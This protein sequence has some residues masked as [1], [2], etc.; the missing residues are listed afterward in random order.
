MPDGNI[1]ILWSDIRY[2]PDGI[3]DRSVFARILKPDGTAVTGDIRVT[4]DNIDSGFA[5]LELT[6]DGSILLVFSSDLDPEGPGSENDVFVRFFSPDDLPKVKKLKP[7]DDDVKL[8]RFDDSVES[9]RGDDKIRAGDGHD[10]IFGQKGNDLLL[11]QS[12]DDLL[13]GGAGNDTLRG[14]PG[15]DLFFGGIGDDVIYVDDDDSFARK[16]QKPAPFD[17]PPTNAHFYLGGWGYDTLVVEKGSTFRFK[18]L[19]TLSIE[20]FVGADGDDR[21]A[22]RG[23]MDNMFKGGGGDDTLIGM[24][25]DD[26]L[27]GGAGD[28]RLLGGHGM[29]VLVGGGG[30]DRLVGDEDRDLLRGGGDQDT[31]NGGRDNDT[32]MGGNGDDSLFGQAGDDLLDGGTGNDLLNGG[33]G[34]D[35]IIGGAG[36]DVLYGSDHNDSI[37]G[38][39]GHDQLFGGDGD[40][41]LNGQSGRDTINGKRGDDTL[42]GGA[43]ADV[44]VFNGA[45]FANSGDDEITDFQNGTD[46]IRFTGPITFDDLTILQTGG[47]TIIEWDEGS[48]TL[49]GVT[50]TIDANDFVFS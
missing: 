40:D 20:A 25:G 41:V 3:I 26:T 13:S 23:T 39:D 38:G 16:F 44:F 4:R 8:T 7:G 48:V 6:K 31:L 36:Q 17:Y 33:N 45:A 43:G 47:K 1:L 18:S 27:Y 32:L 19:D 5:D 35:T 24:H 29:D 14:G 46:L 12:G 49:I 21:V 50:G 15:A 22:H 11:G 2:G 9:G 28:D 34:R 42:S 10:D 37:D 30:K